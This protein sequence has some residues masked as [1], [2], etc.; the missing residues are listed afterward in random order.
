MSL[1]S[2][3]FGRNLWTVYERSHMAQQPSMTQDAE[4]FSA[5][6]GGPRTLTEDGLRAIDAALPPQYPSAEEKLALALGDARQRLATL[7]PGFRERRAAKVGHSSAFS[8]MN[9]DA[10]PRP[11][12]PGLDIWSKQ[13]AVQSLRQGLPLSKPKVS[14]ETKP[15]A[16]L[17]QQQIVGSLP[18]DDCDLDG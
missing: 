15:A 8:A 14:D 17:K 1:W 18:A 4:S 9:L 3:K 7:K 2:L 5:S 11:L 12:G 10:C 16:E 13:S 6:F